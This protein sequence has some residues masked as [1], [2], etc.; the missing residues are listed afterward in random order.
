[1]SNNR[2][3]KQLRTDWDGERAKSAVGTALTGF[4]SGQ[5]DAVGCFVQETAMKDPAALRD[6]FVLLVGVAGSLIVNTAGIEVVGDLPALPADDAAAVVATLLYPEGAD[7]A[8]G[9]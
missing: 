1:M 3:R 2:R 6:A 5:G 8:K 7:D 9:T 4:L